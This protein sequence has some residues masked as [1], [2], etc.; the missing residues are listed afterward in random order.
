MNILKKAGG[1]GPVLFGVG[2]I[3][4]LIAQ[5]LEAASLSAPLGL[6]H[7]TFGLILG[8]SMGVVAQLRGRWV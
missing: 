8:I 4:P 2:F 1:L 5:S 7:I 3:A 6:S